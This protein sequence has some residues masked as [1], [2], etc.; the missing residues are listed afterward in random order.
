MLWRLLRLALWTLRARFR[1]RGQVRTQ[2]LSGLRID[3]PLTD[4]PDATRVVRAVLTITRAN[5]LGR[6][7]VLQQWYGSR[8]HVHDLVIGVTPPSRGFRAHAW[9]ERPGQLTRDDYT[10]VVRLPGGRA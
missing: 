9:L 5:C 10:E 6:S 8:G 7:L 3:P 2:G 4:S 1:A